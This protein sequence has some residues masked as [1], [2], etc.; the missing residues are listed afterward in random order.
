MREI[1]GIPASRIFDEKQYNGRLF[2]SPPAPTHPGWSMYDCIWSWRRPSCSQRLEEVWE[3]FWTKPQANTDQNRSNYIQKSREFRI[4]LG[5]VEFR[6]LGFALY[7]AGETE[8][9]LTTHPLLFEGSYLTLNAAAS[10][11]YMKVE[12]LGAGH[13][14]TGC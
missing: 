8:G 12:V 11:G 1:L 5:Q 6:T 10:E 2:L 7:H 14:I 9:I 13:P 4:V 3:A